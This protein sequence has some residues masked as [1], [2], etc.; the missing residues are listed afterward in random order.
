MEKLINKE[1]ALKAEL[2]LVGD[3]SDNGSGDND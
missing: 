3:D 1:E 2:W